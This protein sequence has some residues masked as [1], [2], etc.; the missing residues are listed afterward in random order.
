MVVSCFILMLDSCVFCSLAIFCYDIL[1][2]TPLNIRPRHFSIG[3]GLTVPWKVKNFMLLLPIF[4]FCALGFQ[5]C[6]LGSNLSLFQ[7]LFKN[8]KNQI[9][10]LFVF[11]KIQDP[12]T[13]KC[14]KNDQRLLNLKII[15]HP[16]K[17]VP[18]HLSRD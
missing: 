2:E 3:N 4:G 8:L 6:L 7:S 16:R 12:P 11:N 15:F 9:K 1:T 18:N 5:L 17:N 14:W 10:E 13:W